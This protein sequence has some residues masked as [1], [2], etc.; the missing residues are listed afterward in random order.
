MNVILNF[1]VAT[2]KI[3]KMEKW[4]LII[5]VVYSN[6]FNIFMMRY[7]TLFFQA[8]MLSCSVMSVVAHQAPLSMRFSRQKCWSGLLFPTPGDLPDPGIEPM[9]PAS[10]ALAGRFFN[11]VPQAHFTLFSYCPWNRYVFHTHSISQFRPG[12]FQEVNSTPCNSLLGKRI[13]KTGYMYIPNWFAL[14][15]TWN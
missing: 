11:T 14:L 13:L 10:S 3:V 7:F 2:L 6:L 9:S 15:Y 1:L 4:M 12:T 5:Y 8:C